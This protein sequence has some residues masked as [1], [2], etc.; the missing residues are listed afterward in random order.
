MNFYNQLINQ[1]FDKND[2]RKLLAIDNKVYDA[3]QFSKK[4][5]G[6]E[7]IISDYIG[8][9]AIVCLDHIFYLV[10]FKFNGFNEIIKFKDAFM[11]FH[12]GNIKL[13]KQKKG[14]L[15]YHL[16]QN[17]FFLIVPPF[18]IPVFNNISICR[19]LHVIKN[20]KVCFHLNY[21]NFKDLIY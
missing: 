9:D 12:D 4:H 8:E 10:L 2:Q 1:L 15:P 17:Y 19:Y 3:T 11:A 7:L 14:S 20:Y 5:P 6:G 16:Q 13:G 21:F 18:L